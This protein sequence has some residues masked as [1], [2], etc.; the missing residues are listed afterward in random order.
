MRTN[1]RSVLGHKSV[2]YHKTRM[3]GHDRTKRRPRRGNGVTKKTYAAAG[4]LPICG[5]LVL[6]GSEPVFRGGQHQI[7]WGAFGGRR[8]IE[9]DGD[10]R[11]TAWREFQEET[12]KAF[13]SSSLHSPLPMS[14][15]AEDFHARC[16]FHC[17]SERA[18][19]ALFLL[20]VP[21]LGVLPQFTD[22][23]AS[24]DD[25]LNKRELRWVPL[26]HLIRAVTSTRSKQTVWSSETDLAGVGKVA[27]FIFHAL[28]DN[29]SVI[30]QRLCSFPDQRSPPEPIL[31]HNNDKKRRLNSVEMTKHRGKIRKR[32]DYFPPPPPPPPTDRI[33]KESS[34]C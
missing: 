17:Y 27:P 21:Y 6:L 18:R 10:A 30:E 9:D 24:R 19:Y 31:E 3:S 1:V 33:S 34:P 7:W 12:G 4:V 26:R 5:D 23:D 22:E 14:F 25:T 32:R 16:R 15:D 13:C 29:C 11:K 20:T 28:R 2:H 8:E